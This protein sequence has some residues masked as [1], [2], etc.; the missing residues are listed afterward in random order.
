MGLILSMQMVIA[1]QPQVQRSHIIT[2]IT[3]Q[4]VIFYAQPTYINIHDN[5]LID[6]AIVGDNKGSRTQGHNNTWNHNT[7][8]GSYSNYGG[9]QINTM[10][11]S[12]QT[13]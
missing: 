13:S 9:A 4:M 10:T 12:R 1:V 7:F 2:F 8:I 6:G 11:Q 5:L 3:T